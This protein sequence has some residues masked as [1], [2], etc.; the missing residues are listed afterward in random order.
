MKRTLLLCMSVFKRQRA[1]MDTSASTCAC[2]CFNM[3]AQLTACFEEREMFKPVEVKVWETIKIG[4][5]I[6]EQTY[7]IKHTTFT[8]LFVQDI[9]HYHED[10]TY[11]SIKSFDIQRSS[12]QKTMITILSIF[13]SGFINPFEE[14]LIKIT[15]CTI[16]YDTLY[17]I[18]IISGHEVTC[19]HS[20]SIE[21]IG[22]SLGKRRG[23]G[24]HLNRQRK[25]V[26]NSSEC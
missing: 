15:Y 26:L 3:H 14:V 20:K 17:L 13:L 9:L 7:W 22:L 8:R 25:E 2:A 12:V 10:R 24:E 11:I 21:T 4:L 16:N 6:K 19:N 5:F 23:I 18:N 1:P